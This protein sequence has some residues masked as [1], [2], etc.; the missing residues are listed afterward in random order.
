MLSRLSGTYSVYRIKGDPVRSEI[1][2][3]FDLV[4]EFREAG[5]FETEHLKEIFQDVKKEIKLGRLI[6]I[7]GIVGS[8]KT[9]LINRLEDDLE[10][11]KEIIVARSLSLDKSKVT[12]SSFMLA[13]FLDL[14]TKGKEKEIKIP[15]PTEKQMR[16]LQEVIQKWKKPVALF[17]DEAHHIHGQT[18]RELKLLIEVVRKGGGLLS[19]VLAG[20][21][22]LK[23]DLRRSIL[24]EIGHRMTILDLDGIVANKRAYIEWLLAK[25]VKA[26]TPIDSV[27]SVEAIDLLADRLVTPLQIEHYLTL[28]VEEAFTIAAKPVTA[29]IVAS[30]IAKDIDELEPKL[31][32]L[33]YNAKTLARILNVRPAVLKSFFQGQLPS[34]RVQELQNEML[35]AG[36]PI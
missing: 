24:E 15:A 25:C 29:D 32:R 5:Y 13:I 4:R 26:E 7:S 34:G 36:I 3:H 27:F 17:V 22:K 14:A 23:N 8:G 16:K 28:A 18:L 30:V 31:T 35:A 6:A 11:E 20:H 33:G 9:L 19:I 2:R 12:L 21:P 10:R 1:M